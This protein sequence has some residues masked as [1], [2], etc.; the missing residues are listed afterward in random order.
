MRGGN[1][2]VWGMGID[3]CFNFSKLNTLRVTPPAQ[4]SVDYRLSDNNSTCCIRDAILDIR[5]SAFFAS[6]LAAIRPQ[7]FFMWM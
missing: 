1:G 6:S 4:S 5:D 2:R 7:F 3:F